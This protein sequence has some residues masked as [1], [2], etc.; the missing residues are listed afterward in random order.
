MSGPAPQGKTGV[1][2]P[3]SFLKIA[4]IKG[5]SR[6][7]NHEG[8]IEVRSWSWGETQD[9]ARASP[10]GDT[11]S[12]RNFQFSATTGAASAQFFLL[13]AQ[14][15]KLKSV[16]LS[17]EHDHKNGKHTYLTI[18][19]SDVR[20]VAFDIEVSAGQDHAVDRVTLRF[21]KIEFTYTPLKPDGTPGSNFSCTW[22]LNS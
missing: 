21:T 2:S 6:S 12:M 18:T 3:H 13:C 7:K 19:L 20:I 10:T 22:D 1:E 11:V 5:D 14:A 8:E 15:K 4:E 17:C 9:V 16:T